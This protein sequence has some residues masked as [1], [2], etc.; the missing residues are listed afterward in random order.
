VWFLDELVARSRG[1]FVEPEEVEAL[2]AD[3][4]EPGTTGSHRGHGL[5]Y[6]ITA[7]RFVFGV[8]TTPR[9]AVDRSPRC[10]IDIDNYITGF[11]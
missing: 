10:G 2:L 4:H 9:N 6:G 7:N 5:P 3:R 11:R 8:H 1:P